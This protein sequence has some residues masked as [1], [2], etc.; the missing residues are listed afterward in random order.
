M[1][2]CNTRRPAHVGDDWE[3]QDGNSWENSPYQTDEFRRDSTEQRQAR[4]SAQQN[5]H[6][7]E[8]ER[9]EAARKQAG[10]KA[11]KGSAAQKKW[12]EQLRQAFIAANPDLKE[13]V[14]ADK[15]MGKAKTWI[16]TRKEA[17]LA[18]RG[19]VIELKLAS[20]LF[21]QANRTLLKS[22]AEK[23]PDLRPGGR[24]PID[25][26]TDRMMRARDDAERNMDAIILRYFAGW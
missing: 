3:D 16:D 12:G 21:Q 5:R 15:T 1:S 14:A 24:F 22:L 23:F 18:L 9:A 11:L 4:L 7:A 19:K 13:F 17:P 8:I 2:V 26:E 6:G 25:A 20:E 10:L